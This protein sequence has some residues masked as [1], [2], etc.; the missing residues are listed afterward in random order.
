M[1]ISKTASRIGG[2]LIGIAG[3]AILWFAYLSH[4]PTSDEETTLNCEG[5]MNGSGE[6]MAW[7]EG[8]SFMMGEEGAYPEEGPAHAEHLA[9]FW[10]SRHE[11]SN[12]QFAEFVDATGYVTVAERVPS[13]EEYPDIPKE[14]L[15]PGSAVF[16]VP[17]TFVSTVNPLAW[18]QFRKDANWRHPN[19]PGTTIKGREH[20][21]VVHMAQE[22]ALAYAKWRGHR[23]PTEAEYEF[24]ARGGLEGAA[25]AGG[26]E[27]APSGV[28]E[29]NTWQGLFPFQNTGEDG[30]KGLAPVGCYEP[31][32]YGLH[33]MIGNVWEW[34]S[35]PYYP[36]HG[37][38]V[39]PPQGYDP[40]Q[41]G[42]PVRVI[43][44]GSFLCAPNYCMRYRPAARHA[45]ETGLGTDHIGFRMVREASS[46]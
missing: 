45:Q 39:D 25:F 28:H 15:V 10:I 11:V 40:R 3:L 41:P 20:F 14:L 6:E 38:F 31:N 4:D 44:G 1:T 30:F 35:D 46:Q 34:T 24:A 13:P 5:S 19:G 18:W 7:I 43:K 9:G 42:L 36:V 26:E 32:A 8:G 12:S 21:P 22:D 37:D 27:L 23:L 17:E 33:D 2:F 16:V 29:A